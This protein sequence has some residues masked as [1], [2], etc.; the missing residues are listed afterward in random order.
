MSTG[1]I[2][3]IGVAAA[4]SIYQG[5]RGFRLQWILG[6]K[7]VKTTHDRV[8]LL[9]VADTIV[10]SICSASGFGALWLA[11]E[12]YTRIPSLAELSS[13]SAI[14][15]LSLALFGLLGVIGYLPYLFQTGRLPGAGGGKP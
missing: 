7:A 5:Y 12:L 4:A 10:Y 1:L 14:L 11:Y 13:G 3:Y 8:L 6:I 2:T 15:L 9:C